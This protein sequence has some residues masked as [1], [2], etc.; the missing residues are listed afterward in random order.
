MISPHRGVLA[1]AYRRINNALPYEI[2]IGN[3]NIAL[4]CININYIMDMFNYIISCV[5]RV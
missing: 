2:I 4:N 1:R 3:I 5:S